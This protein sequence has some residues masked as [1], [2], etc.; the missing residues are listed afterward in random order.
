MASKSEVKKNYAATWGISEA[1]QRVSALIKSLESG[2]EIDSAISEILQLDQLHLVACV[3]GAIDCLQYLEGVEESC[4]RA[5]RMWDA[6][7]KHVA[8]VRERAR[9]RI[10]ETIEQNPAVIYEGHHGT[11]D[12]RKNPGSLVIDLDLRDKSISN[13]IQPNVDITQIP[14]EFLEQTTYLTL[15]KERLK[16][17]I[18]SGRVSVPWAR[19]VR[20]NRLSI[21]DP[22][23]NFPT[24]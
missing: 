9:Q 3:D 6:R 4:L 21:G 24:D 22:G 11:L 16:D 10:R 17:A 19:I 20:E 8:S 7:A 23:A 13:V 14:G 1:A 18:K 5:K 12:I 2:E 15:N